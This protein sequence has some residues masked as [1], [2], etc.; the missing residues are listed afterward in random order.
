MKTNLIHLAM[1]TMLA[2]GMVAC[3][4]P[5]GFTIEH[6]GDTLTVVHVSAPGKYLL[7]PIQESSNEGKVK[8]ETGSP[9][10]MAMDVR[11]AV[12]SIEYYVPFEIPQ[13]GDATVSI[14]KVVADAVCWEHIQ[15]TD[16]FDTSNTDYY[17][18]VYH[19]TP[20]YGW[21]NDPNG[22]VYKDG[23]YHLYFQYNPYGS[24]WGN[25]HWGH[26][27]STDL[28]HWNHLK[29]AIARDTLGHIFSGSTVVDK[30][31]TAG[32]GDNA[33]IALYTS[34]SDEHGQIQ[35]MAYSTDDGRTYT[36]YEKN[37]VLLPFDGLKDFRDPKVFWYEPDKKWVMIVSADKEMRFYASQN[38]KDWE[39]MSAFGKG[40]GAQPNQFECPDFIQL[41]V[42]GDKNKMKWVMLVNINPGCM[43]GGS[44]TEYF[45]GDFDGKEFTCDTKPE[46]VKWLDYGKDH[47]AAVCISNTGERIISIPW[48]SN[49]QYANVTPIRQY[50][51]ANGLPRE[52][53][54]YTKDGQI[55]VAADVVKEVEALRKD[56]RSF[57]PITVKDEYK[58]DEIVPQTDGAYELEMDITPNT[59][60]VAGFD[61]MN[62]KGEVAKIYLDMKSGKLVMDRTASGLVAFGEKSEPH[63][64]ETDDHRKTMSVNYQNDFALG[65]WAPLSLCEG[66]TYH[67]NV[68]VD[69]CSVEIFVDGGRIAMTNLVFPTEPYNTLRFYTEG[70]EAQVSNMKVYKLG[71]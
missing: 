48:M 61:L 26:S 22:M 51:G 4:S 52:L 29:P 42:D 23:E 67:L 25:M 66:K 1:G 55:Y 58:I 36:K 18:P 3:Q 30:N 46:T 65:T 57:D 60:G 70:G 50:R 28:I 6:Q 5:K 35:C 15:L 17:R 32:Y 20:L 56:T 59:S 44:A 19:H 33:L 13:G 27:V 10:D 43:F 41:P 63:A 69:K 37:P 64:K 11:L 14:R 9:A 34:A 7:L 53:S 12:D 8:L 54:L 2:C 71:L 47:Y 24:K 39:Y 16:T 45:V 40:Y 38:L 21:M 31:N 62:A 68:F 49:W